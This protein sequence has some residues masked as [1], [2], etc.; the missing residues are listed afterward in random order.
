VYRCVT[1]TALETKVREKPFIPHL[2][3]IPPP[4]PESCVTDLICL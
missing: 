4:P 1:P 2:F 3:E